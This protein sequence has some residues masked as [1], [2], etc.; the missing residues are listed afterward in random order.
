MFGR[1]L[2]Y[3]SD[4]CLIETCSFGLASTG[5]RTAKGRGLTMPNRNDL[6]RLVYEVERLDR[7]RAAD[8]KKVLKW[9]VEVWVSCGEA[10]VAPEVV[11]MNEGQKTKQRE[12][13]EK[14]E[15]QVESRVA[16]LRTMGAGSREELATKQAEIER[17]KN[18]IDDVRNPKRRPAGNRLTSGNNNSFG[19]HSVTVRFGGSDLFIIIFSI[20]IY[21][22][23][24][25]VELII[26]GDTKAIEVD[27]SPNLSLNDMKSK[28][29]Y[30]K[31]P[32]EYFN[33]P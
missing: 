3:P 22:W 12:A 13:V 17:L 16:E 31:V 1:I 32:L 23:I 2:Q 29:R 5:S 27:R 6:K 14:A 19:S 24:W 18:Y 33:L 7:S 11:S 4:I 28:S 8:L 20:D 15:R 10:F 21:I 25:L 26:M 30:K 9:P